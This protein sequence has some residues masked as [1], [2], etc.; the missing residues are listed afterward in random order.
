MSVVYE[1]KQRR[2]LWFILFEVYALVLALVQLHN[3]VR[4]DEAKYLL[5]IPYPHPPLAR[6]L[7]HLVDGWIYQELFWRI[8]FATFLVQAVWFLI[9]LAG[10]LKPVA[11]GALGASWLFS[12]AV[13]LQAGT[14]MM[15][16]LTALEMLLFLFLLLRDDTTKHAGLIGLLWLASLFT[17]YQAV[18]FFPIVIALLHRYNGTRARKMAAFFVPVALLAL[19]TLSNPLAVAAMTIH[20][21]KDAAD[22]LATRID[23][24][25]HVWFLGGGIVLSIVGLQGMIRERA[26]AIFASF[27]L[28]SAYVLLARFDYYAILFTPLCACGFLLLLRKHH[29]A[30][31]P[32]AVGTIIGTAFLLLSTPLLLGPSSAQSAMQRLGAL[33]LKQ[34]VLIA[35]PFGHEWQYASGDV[36]ILRYAPSLAEHA[37]A[38]VCTASCPDID[39]AKAWKRL[40]TLKPAMYVRK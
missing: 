36:T 4:T 21:G 35:G 7:L 14:V 33:G 28:V 11:R 30:A 1:A 19:Y 8:V 25:L 16:P 37:G 39:A 6:F 34:P 20:A 29:V 18:L 12:A 24:F 32:V 13:I 17:A 31:L 26:A 22:T 23:A 27:L 5:N 15:A 2:F 38:I 40:G 9:D 3:G 10:D